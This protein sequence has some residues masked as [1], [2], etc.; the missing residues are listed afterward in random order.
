MRRW[1]QQQVHMTIGRAKT[2]GRLHDRSAPLHECYTIPCM[3][4]RFPAVQ[5]GRVIVSALPSIA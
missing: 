1:W 3:K 2:P 4:G 5:L